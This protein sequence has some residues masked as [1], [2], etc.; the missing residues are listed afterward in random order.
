MKVLVTG[1]GGFIGSHLCE[2]LVNEG[3][4]VR[5][6]VRYNS[7]N[8]WG[9]LEHSSVKNEIEVIQGDIIDFDSVKKATKDVRIIFHLAALISIPYSYQVQQGFVNVNIKG[10]LNLMQ[11]SLLNGIEKFIHTSTSEVYG[12]AQYVPMDENHPINPESPYAAT[13][14]AADYLA[15]SF[16][17]SFN[18]PVVILRP[19][20]VYG[21]RQSARAVIPTIITQI[22]SGEKKINLG[23][24]HPT[25]DFTYVKDT[26][27]GF[28]L[29]EKINSDNI[30]GKVINIGSNFEISIEKLAQD[31]AK[32]MEVNIEL[33]SEE[34]RKRPVKSEV[35][36]LWAENRIAKELLGWT[37]NC[38][39][40]QG[41]KITIDWFKKNINF[42]KPEIY[43]V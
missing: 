4:E 34:K 19:F 15:L 11:A 17:K 16:Y 13:K 14:A 31:I 42:Y 18:L 22:L 21:P 3:Y 8:F 5:A 27:R 37:P 24:L 2:S 25:R 39:L 23:A 26:V 10:M 7:K 30:L 9:W 29:A 38:S 6:L 40:E 20:N 36:R 43:N 28:I 12:T 33:S 41:L 35:K 1:A 32:L